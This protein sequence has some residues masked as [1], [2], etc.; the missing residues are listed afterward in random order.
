[1]DKS[2]KIRYNSTLK[3]PENLEKNVFH[4]IFLLFMDYLGENST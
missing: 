4:P 1:M 2:I 3:K